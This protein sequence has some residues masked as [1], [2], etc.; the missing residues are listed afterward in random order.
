[1]LLNLFV[2]ESFFFHFIPYCEGF[3]GWVVGLEEDKNCFRESDSCSIQLYKFNYL[4]KNIWLWCTVHTTLLRDPYSTSDF[5]Q[6]QNF[7]VH[8]PQK[9]L[10][11]DNCRLIWSRGILDLLLVAISSQILG[12]LYWWWLSPFW[13]FYLSLWR[14]Y[15]ALWIGD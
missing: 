13:W 11:H 3:G 7:S 12:G 15:D 8:M 6:L 14:V 2:A 9:N 5:S 4:F 10:G 1:M